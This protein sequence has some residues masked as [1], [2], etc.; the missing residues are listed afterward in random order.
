MATKRSAKRE[1][2]VE[3]EV[4][5]AYTIHSARHMFPCDAR[6]GL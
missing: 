6:S 3:K 1:R 2:Q 5:I 4:G